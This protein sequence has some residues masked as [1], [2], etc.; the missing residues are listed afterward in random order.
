MSLGLG[1]GPL[2]AAVPA[3]QAQVSEREPMPTEWHRE[4]ELPGQQPPASHLPPAALGRA[5]LRTSLLAVGHRRMHPFPDGDPCL[6]Q[7][8]QRPFGWPR[9]PYAA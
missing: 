8:L 7:L 5:L 1:A 9:G 4:W 3:P 6:F 2:P